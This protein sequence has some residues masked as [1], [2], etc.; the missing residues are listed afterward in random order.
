MKDD[1]PNPVK[2]VLYEIIGKI[3]EGVIEKNIAS[4]S[5]I[6][7]INELIAEGY[8]KIIQLEGDKEENI[9]KF[10]TSLLHYLLTISLIPSQRKIAPQDIDIDIVIPDLKTL[11]TKP[12]NSLIICIPEL[13]KEKSIEKQIQEIE[14]IQPHN[15]N[16]WLAVENKQKLDKKS[17]AVSDRTISKII[18]DINQFLSSKKTTPFKIFRV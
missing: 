17:Y 9:A 11:S 14:T 5:S 15:D 18:Q 1:E 16:I 8:P 6:D 7:I 2:D 13:R 4:G 10:S 3:T 12:E